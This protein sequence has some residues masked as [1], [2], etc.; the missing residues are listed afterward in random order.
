M[1]RRLRRGE[2]QHEHTANL[3]RKDEGRHEQGR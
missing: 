3:N 2:E 1:R